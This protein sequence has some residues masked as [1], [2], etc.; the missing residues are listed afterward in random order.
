MSGER[1][2]ALDAE[3]GGERTQSSE[4]RLLLVAADDESLHVRHARD[5]FEQH[6]DALPR[7]EVAGVR[8][9]AGG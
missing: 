9:G 6:V 4:V 5:R 7:V 3:P 8:D 2:P 1:H